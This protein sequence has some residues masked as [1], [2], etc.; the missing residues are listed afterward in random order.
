MGERAWPGL[1]RREGEGAG[2][3]GSSGRGIGIGKGITGLVQIGSF[4]VM[5]FTLTSKIVATTK[6]K[7][8]AAPN[9]I[10]MKILL[11]AGVRPGSHSVWVYR[12]CVNINVVPFCAET[13][14][15]PPKWPKWTEMA[16]N[17]HN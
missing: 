5:T 15:R 8:Q 3:K 13:V 11:E 17:C 12:E 9:L 16:R 7:K 2:V 1:G 4:I 10:K 6:S 14:Q